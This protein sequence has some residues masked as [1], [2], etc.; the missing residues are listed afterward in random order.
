MKYLGMVL[1]VAV[2]GAM[3]SESSQAALAEHGFDGE[4]SVLAGYS[5]QESNFNTDNAVKNGELNSRGESDSSIVVFPLGQLRYTFGQGAKSQ[6]FLGTAR[7]DVITGLVAL[8]AGYKREVGPNSSIALSYLPT[9]VN[10]E[11]WEDPFVLN[12]ARKETDASGNAVRLQYDNILGSQLNLDLAWFE[13][14]VD[15]ERSGAALAADDMDALRRDGDGWYS[16]LSYRLPVGQGAILAPALRYQVFDAD[17]DAMSYTRWQADA[18]YVRF[19]GRHRYSLSAEYSNYDF[20]ASHPVFNRT[21]EDD[22]WGLTMG[23]EYAD[24]FGW[25]DWA[26]TG[27]ISFSER[28]SN[29]NFYD[30]TERFIVSAG[31]TYHF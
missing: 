5:S 10:D 4:L 1:S 16:R 9:V 28:D 30:E 2:S 25:Q 22:Q 6:L 29:I 31:V 21:R 14:E 3:V 12:A 26:F 19:I 18:T 11:T 27:I 17:G 8:E 15:K 13:Q 23:Y 24:I 20:D 7:E